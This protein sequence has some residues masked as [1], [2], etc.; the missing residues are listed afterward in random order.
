MPTARRFRRQSEGAAVA[1]GSDGA[2]DV[3]AVTGEVGVAHGDELPLDP[4]ERVADGRCRESTA[5]VPDVELRRCRTRP[6]CATAGRRHRP[7]RRTCRSGRGSRTATPG[8]GKPCATSI[9]TMRRSCGLSAERPG[10][11]VGEEQRGARRRRCD[12]TVPRASA[13]PASSPSVTS[14]R[15]ECLVECVLDDRRA[16]RPR[17][18]RAAC[19]LDAGARDAVDDRRVDR[20]VRL[21]LVDHQPVVSRPAPLRA[22]DLDEVLTATDQPV[23]RRR[24]PVRRPP[25]RPVRA[26]APRAARPRQMSGAPGESVDAGV[27][28]SRLAPC[29]ERFVA[30][31][32]RRGRTSSWSHD[33][34][35]PCCCSERA[36][37]AVLSMSSIRRETNDAVVRHLDPLWRQ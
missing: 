36:R 23:Q 19:A 14:S 24:R 22:R 4:T 6:R 7:G 16:A 34:N 12:P 28:A 2:G 5:C 32:R 33:A 18:G 11:R 26:S 35:T 27:H 20:V 21:G 30:P 8:A 31:R 25:S 15:A 29:D 13:A 1:D 10:T 9:R 3:D 37:R 17:R